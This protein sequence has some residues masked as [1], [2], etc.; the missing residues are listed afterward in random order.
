MNEEPH[1]SKKVFMAVAIAPV[2]IFALAIALFL[3]LLG[4]M[5]ISRGGFLADLVSSSRNP[6]VQNFILIFAGYCCLPFLAIIALAGPPLTS[7][8]ANRKFP[9]FTNRS[10]AIRGGGIFLAF[11]VL[12]LVILLVFRLIENY[13]SLQGS[14]ITLQSTSSVYVVLSLLGIISYFIDPLLCLLSIV[15]IA[16]S[17]SV[18]AAGRYG[19]QRGQSQANIKVNIR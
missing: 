11:N 13:P 10:R 19:A 7:F 5:E 9:V 14:L 16:L 1:I 2:V 12:F 3:P 6:F 8:I 18:A 15:G 4:A 17:C